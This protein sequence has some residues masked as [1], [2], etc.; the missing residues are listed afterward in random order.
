MKPSEK[1]QLAHDLIIQH[2]AYITENPMYYRYLENFNSVDEA[3]KYLLCLV[4]DIK[5]KIR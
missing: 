3:N 5:E 4:N 2:L 1:K